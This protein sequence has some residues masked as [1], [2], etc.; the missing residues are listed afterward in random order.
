MIKRDGLN[1]NWSLFF[2]PQ[3]TELVIKKQLG[4]AMLWALDFD[5]F[6]NICGYGAYPIGNLINAT[7]AAAEMGVS[8]SPPP[9]KIP[10]ATLPPVTGHY[11]PNPNPN[12]NTNPIGGGS[13]G[14]TFC[15]Q[16]PDGMYQHSVDCSKYIRCVGE[17]MFEQDC[18]PSLVFDA[19]NSRC[20]WDYNVKCTI[21]IQ[22][23]KSNVIYSTTDISSINNSTKSPMNTSYHIASCPS[24]FIIYCFIFSFFCL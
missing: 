6:R 2:L 20:D 9:T 12:P 10:A 24:L 11:T 8:V 17:E 19:V 16:H 18:P 22:G 5:D 3:V 15:S 7:L 23:T 1:V 14:D 21:L 4:G 13:E